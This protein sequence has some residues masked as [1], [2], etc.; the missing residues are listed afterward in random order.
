MN[1]GSSKHASTRRHLWE[2]WDQNRTD[3][4]NK[5]SADVSKP[6]ERI[7]FILVDLSITIENV[8]LNGIR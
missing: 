3:K 4:S 1:L 2:I 7:F 8:T 5:I 6:L